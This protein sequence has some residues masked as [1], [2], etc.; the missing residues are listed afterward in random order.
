MLETL[1]RERPVIL[2][3]APTLHKLSMLAFNCV[4]I[5]EKVIRLHP[6][7]C[8]GF[9]ADFDGDQM[10]IHVPLSEEARLEACDLLLATRNVLHP[11]SGAPAILP[12]Q[13]MVLGLYY[14][15]LVDDGEI[16]IFFGTYP[17]VRESLAKG[18]V[19]L[20]TRVKF[21]HSVNGRIEA[22][23]TTPGRLLI[24]RLIPKQLNI[25]Y[26]ADMPD[27]T[28]ENLYQLVEFVSDKCG[29]QQM[30]TFCEKLMF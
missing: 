19:K 15:S 22:T 21:L 25:L 11:A 2:N 9:N 7:V 20:H 23:T 24:S 1:V 29:L 18:E 26:T 30:A 3:R 12:N 27:L 17:D 16:T 14:A 6:L 5:D 10:A 28:K 8:S 4:I 13:D